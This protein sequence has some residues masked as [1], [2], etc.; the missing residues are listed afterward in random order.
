MSLINKK[1]FKENFFEP[2]KLALQYS[3][4]GKPYG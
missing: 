4:P 3:L 2:Y 1:L